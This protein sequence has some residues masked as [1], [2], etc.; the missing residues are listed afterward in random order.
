M[1][2]ISLWLKWCNVLSVIMLIATPY[3][4]QIL[5][6]FFDIIKFDCCPIACAGC[7]RDNSF[8]GW[9]N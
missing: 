3:Q 4:V 2:R 7:A 5:K 9:N 1:L 8:A 6:L